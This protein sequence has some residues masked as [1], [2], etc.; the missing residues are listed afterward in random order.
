M[1]F[2]GLHPAR[3]LPS[4]RSLRSLG[5]PNVLRP[6]QFLRHHA[7][8]L[9][10]HTAGG[11]RDE[12]AVDG[13]TDALSLGVGDAAPPH[14][15]AVQLRR[16]LEQLAVV[17]LQRLALLDAL[18]DLEAAERDHHHADAEPRRDQELRAQQ[19]AHGRREGPG[20]RAQRARRHP[21]RD[22]GDLGQRQRHRCQR[23]WVALQV[24]DRG[25]RAVLQ[26]VRLFQHPRQQ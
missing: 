25:R 15:D 26:A 22:V 13:G 10:Q 4:F 14:L 1:S 16:H 5:P 21:R 2:F 6:P 18:D 8:I 23:V 24:L 17:P 19:Q 20:Q 9:N 3:F 7:A 11:R 12:L